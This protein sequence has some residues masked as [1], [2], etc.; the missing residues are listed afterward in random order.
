MNEQDKTKEQLIEELQ[1][2]RWELLHQT[3]EMPV[4]VHVV[5]RD[6]LIWKSCQRIPRPLTIFF[7]VWQMVK[8]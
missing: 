2:T 7:D 1:E 5:D 6:G 4:A 8:R 3:E